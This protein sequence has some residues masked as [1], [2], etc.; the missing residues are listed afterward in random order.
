MTVVLGQSYTS[1]SLCEKEYDFGPTLFS[2]LLFSSKFVGQ[3]VHFA[4]SF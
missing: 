4:A 2:A 3:E 1:V